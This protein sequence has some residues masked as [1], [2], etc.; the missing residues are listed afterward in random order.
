[1]ACSGFPCADDIGPAASHAG[2]CPECW[3]RS[4]SAPGS[5]LQVAPALGADAMVDVASVALRSENP[6]GLP[7]VATLV[8][9]VATALMCRSSSLSVPGRSAT[10]ARRVQFKKSLGWMSSADM[11]SSTQPLI[12]STSVVL[13]VHRE[14]GR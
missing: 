4:A 5:H 10:G 1:M 11:H 8:P 7:C 13:V 2:L 6:G 12:G 9:G 14:A 3:V